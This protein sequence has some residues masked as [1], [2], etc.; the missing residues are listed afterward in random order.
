MTYIQPLAQEIIQ[1]TQ[2][3]AT[4]VRSMITCYNFKLLFRVMIR[5]GGESLWAEGANIC[6]IFR[7]HKNVFC[8]QLPDILTS[9]F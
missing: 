4:F 2:I 3:I 7:V 8:V 6:F 5:R 9:H 1:H